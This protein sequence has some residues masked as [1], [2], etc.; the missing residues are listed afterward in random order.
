MHEQGRQESDEAHA[1]AL[2]LEDAGHSVVAIGDFT[3]ICGLMS[4]A[5]QARPNIAETITAI[6]ELG[7]GTVVMLTGDNQKTAAALAKEVGI[8]RFYAEL[9]PENKVE[10]IEELKQSHRVVA[11]VGDGVNDAPALAASSCGI[12]MGAMG[13][14]VAFETADI[15][16][17]KDDLGKIPWLIRHSRKALTIVKQNI[18]FALG[19]KVIF[20]TLAS[21]ELATLWMAIAADTGA[22]LLVV[23][24]G[25]RL[26]SWKSTE[27]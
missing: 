13:S 12:A 16:L 14:D 20:I 24:N 19:V 11:M 25:L 9:L 18:G 27:S 26:L 1:K 3:H 17:M 23:F 15:V 7:I 6:K 2:E 8:D 22:S 5:D 4:F 21:F 10:K